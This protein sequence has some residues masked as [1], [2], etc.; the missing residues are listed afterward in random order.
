MG[1]SDV[2]K[3]GGSCTG[4][5]GICCLDRQALDG[6]DTYPHW[7]NVFGERRIGTGERIGF[8]NL[9]GGRCGRGLNIN[10][11]G[12]VRHGRRSC[13]CLGAGRDND[14]HPH[15][16]TGKKRGSFGGNQVCGI[17]RQRKQG[18]ARVFSQHGRQPRTLGG[19]GDQRGAEDGLAGKDRLGHYSAHNPLGFRSQDIQAGIVILEDGLL[20]ECIGCDHIADTQVMT[21]RKYRD[22]GWA[23]GCTQG[24]KQD[25][26]QQE[27]ADRYR[28][29]NEIHAGAHQTFKHGEPPRITDPGRSVRQPVGKQGCLPGASRGVRVPG[30][31]RRRK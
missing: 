30:A 14:R 13:L 3:V 21:G 25:K 26:G 27:D 5:A 23:L 9:G 19:F 4:L 17:H 24:V 1:L 22:G 2:V 18:I 20:H 31:S 7:K 16:V 10:R 11:H 15:Q 29:H 8:G 6:D 12:H 28:Q